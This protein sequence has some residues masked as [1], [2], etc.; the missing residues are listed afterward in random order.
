VKKSPKK[1]P[2][3]SRKKSCPKFCPLFVL[4]KKLPNV[5]N[6]PTGENS[7]NR[8]TL[9]EREKTGPLRIPLKL[10]AEPRKKYI[11]RHWSIPAGLPDG[12]FSNQKSQ[13]G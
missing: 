5:K 8:V 12:I 11:H 6:R 2:K 10:N 7:P 3:G 1:Q 4:F 9:H 13:F